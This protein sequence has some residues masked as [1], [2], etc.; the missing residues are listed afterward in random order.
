MILKLERH[1]LVVAAVLTIF[2]GMACGGGSSSEREASDD[3]LVGPESGQIQPTALPRPFEVAG[4]DPSPT[5]QAGAG[6]WPFV[7][8]APEGSEFFPIGKDASGRYPGDVAVG[9]R[10]WRH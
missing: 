1:H 10:H 7:M 3:G 2:I 5:P 8:T 6:E 9:T 4:V